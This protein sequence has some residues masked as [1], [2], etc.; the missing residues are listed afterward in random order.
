MILTLDF[1]QVV[2]AKGNS[3]PGTI[4]GNQTRPVASQY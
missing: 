4:V 3:D 2:V 1:H